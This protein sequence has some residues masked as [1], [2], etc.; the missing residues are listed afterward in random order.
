MR[1]KEDYLLMNLELPS[2]SSADSPV[3]SPAE[4]NYLLSVDKFLRYGD[5]SLNTRLEEELLTDA[6]RIINTILNKHPLQPSRSI[7]LNKLHNIYCRFSESKKIHNLK[8]T[9]VV[10]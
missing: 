4:V 9:R 5:F 1:Q 6:F 7:Y 8:C 2:P 10:N 3:A